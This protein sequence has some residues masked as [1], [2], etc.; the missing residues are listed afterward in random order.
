MIL[1]VPYKKLRWPL[2]IVFLILG[3]QTLWLLPI[4]NQK[5]LEFIQTDQ[6]IS[7]YHHSVYIALETVKLLILLWV[8]FKG[9][10]IFKNE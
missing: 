2:R 5:V 9:L 4:L 3:I 8:G 6:M 7:S 10:Q 1:L